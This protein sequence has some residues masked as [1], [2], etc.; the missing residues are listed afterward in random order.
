[1][2]SFSVAISLFLFY[3]VALLAQATNP[4]APRTVVDFGAKPDDN[5]S[6]AAA[7]QAAI[8][9]YKRGEIAEILIPSGKFDIDRT[10]EYKTMGYT[11]GIMIRGL[12]ETS[13]LVYSKNDGSPLFRIDG[14]S[15][16]SY[17]FQRGGYIKDLKITASKSD[18]T[19]QGAAIEILG[20]WRYEIS[21]ICIRSW[22]GN[23]IYF[24]QRPDIDAN[25]DAWASQVGNIH[26][27]EIAFCEGWGIRADIST[28]FGGTVIS[29]CSI[30]ACKGGGI[31]ASG[32]AN[33]VV[34]CSIFSNGKTGKGNNEGG[35]KL[36]RTL[37]ASPMNWHI[38]YCELDSNKDYNVSIEGAVNILIEYCRNNSWEAVFK[39]GEMSPKVHF[40]IVPTK[41]AVNINI[42]FNG[43]IHRWER[44]DKGE[45]TCYDLGNDGNTGSVTIR[46]P[47][48]MSADL[49]KKY[50][51]VR[52]NTQVKIEERNVQLD[53]ELFKATKK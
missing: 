6:D 25:P 15:Q 37:G 31:L 30:G 46:N 47:F 41:G 29:S 1:M 11:R 18:F 35:I 20:W 32:S 49:Q 52:P 26:N 48:Y 5:K 34:H 23:G 13:V 38:A 27:N 19:K 53:T 3:N 50:A 21:S 40:R 33:E 28:G 51:N 44:A 14:C 4:F 2:R 7:F 22:G 8:D 10:L 9:A 43:N 45:V 39:D 36:I 24:P 17:Q 12:G 42:D 16:R